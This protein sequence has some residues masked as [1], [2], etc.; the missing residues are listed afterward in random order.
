[1]GK[2]RPPS[3]NVTEVDYKYVVLLLLYEWLYCMPFSAIEW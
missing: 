1:M 2:K 3:Q